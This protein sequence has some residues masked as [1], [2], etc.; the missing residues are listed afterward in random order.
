MQFADKVDIGEI[1]NEFDTWPDRIINLRIT[2]TSFDCLKKSLF[3][4]VISIS[5]LVLM[6]SS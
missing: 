5:R 2:L 6:R 4:F 1:S 3:D